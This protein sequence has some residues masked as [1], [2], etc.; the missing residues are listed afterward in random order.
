MTRATC[1]DTFVVKKRDLKNDHFS[2]V[3]APFSQASKFKP[4]Q[5]VHVRMPATEIYF[6]RAFSVAALNSKKEEIEIIFKVF[7]RG[8]R[9]LGNLDKGDNVDLMGPLGKSFTFPE[10]GEKV[11]MVAGGIGF[12]PLMFLAEE[13]VKRNYPPKSIH[14]FYGARNG[15]D[16]VERARIKKLGVNLQLVTDDG[17]LGEKGLVTRPVEEFL[18]KHANDKIRIYGCGPERMLRATDELGLKYRIPGQLALEA[19]MPCGIGICLSC[20]VALKGG[21]Y[22]RVCVDGPVF[23]IGVVKFES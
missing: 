6:R 5:F 11:V 8:T 14:F 17:T 2:L 20:V 4:G 13:L 18:K 1:E 15:A 10:K 23:D 3:L 7:G 19:L 21:G 12:P 9:I 16:L 22:D